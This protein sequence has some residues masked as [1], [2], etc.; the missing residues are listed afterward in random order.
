MSE[1]L[2]VCEGC[3]ERTAA[4]RC[5]GCQKVWYCNKEC[6]TSNWVRHIFKCKPHRPINTADHLALAVYEDLLPTDAQTLKEWGFDK[7]AFFEPSGPSKLFG[8]YVGLINYHKI[9]PQQ[10]HKWRVGGTLLAEIKAAYDDIPPPARGEYY[11]WFLEHQSVLLEFDETETADVGIDQAMVSMVEGMERRAW[12]AMG[13]SPT[14]S[15]ATIRSYALNL[16]MDQ[17]ACFQLWMLILS[18]SHPNPAM[19]L[20]L[21]FGFCI[22]PTESEETLLAH[23]YRLLIVACTFD[24]FGEAY[25]SRT[26]VRLFQ[27]KNIPMHGVRSDWLADVLG[28]GSIKTVWRL[29]QFIASDGQET[30]MRSATVDYGFRNCLDNDELGGQLAGLYKM[31]FEMSDADP[32]KLH[33]AC[34]QGRLFRFFTDDMRMKLPGSRKLFKRLLKNPYPLPN[35]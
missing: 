27:A 29:K 11:S 12:K 32:L 7:A 25:S 3:L 13:K 9:K 34:V 6:Q 1:H 28:R 15:I 10:L 2:H 19:P 23:A 30:L 22:C 20:Y 17:Q 31:F 16:P 5:T 24:E 35:Y 4:R 33:A 21:S 14:A 18:F 8:V 26:L